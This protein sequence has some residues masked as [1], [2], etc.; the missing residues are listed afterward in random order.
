MRKRFYQILLQSCMEYLIKKCKYFIAFYFFILILSSISTS[1]YFSVI[2]FHFLSVSHKKLPVLKAN[3]SVLFFLNGKKIVFPA[4]ISQWKIIRIT[5]IYCCMKNFVQTQQ[6]NGMT[7]H[8]VSVGSECILLSLSLKSHRSMGGN[9]ISI[10]A[11]LGHT[12]LRILAR[13][14]TGSVSHC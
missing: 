2:L 5:F 1:L 10:K 8:L 13:L 14:L 3:L 12:M 11:L 4:F 9:I 6:L 7:I